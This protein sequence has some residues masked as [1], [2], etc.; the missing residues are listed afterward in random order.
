MAVFPA[1]NKSKDQTLALRRGHVLTGRKLPEKQE[2]K[3]SRPSHLQTWHD[4]EKVSEDELDSVP[5]SIHLS[6]PD[7]TGYL[8]WIYIYS[9]YYWGGGEGGREAEGKEGE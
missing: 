7:G 2:I 3:T 6:I 5:H 4:V 1:Q 8:Y 9:Y